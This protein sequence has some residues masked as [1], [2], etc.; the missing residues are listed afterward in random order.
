METQIYVTLRII[1]SPPVIRIEKWNIQDNCIHRSQVIWITKQGNQTNVTDH[2]L[3][4]PF[5]I[6]AQRPSSYPREKDLEISQ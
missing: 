2:P 4:T 6:L 5:E 1:R 3:T